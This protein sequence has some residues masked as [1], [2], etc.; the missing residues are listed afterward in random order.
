MQYKRRSWKEIIDPA[1]DH[2][3]EI[4]NNALDLIKPSSEDLLKKLEE[5]GIRSFK[6]FYEGEETLHTLTEL[7]GVINAHDLEN[8]VRLF[9]EGKEKGSMEIPYEALMSIA[10]I[11]DDDSRRRYKEIFEP[12]SSDA[13]RADVFNGMDDKG[14]REWIQNVGSYLNSLLL[15]KFVLAIEKIGPEEKKEIIQ[16]LSAEQILFLYFKVLDQ[17]CFV[18]NKKSLRTLYKEA[19]VDNNRVSLYKI[20]QFDKALFDH[21]WVRDL[22][23]RAMITNDDAFL[24]KVGYAIKTEPPI[25]KVKTWG[26]LKYMLLSC[27]R[28]G[29]Y[30]LS[31]PQLDDLLNDSNISRPDDLEGFIKN[32]IKP[33]FPD[34]K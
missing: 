32:E 8:K 9:I 27:W 11:F 4:Y 2:I 28:S 21:E 18:V 24:N 33:L 34:L 13:K 14:I 22:M 29:L 17:V 1:F 20:L 31:V 26:R 30:K 5:S 16:K 6:L 23:F 7:A 25:G 3:L 19:K 10:E 15:H 12:L